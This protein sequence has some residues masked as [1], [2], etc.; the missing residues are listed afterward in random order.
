[1]EGAGAMRVFALMV[2]MGPAGWV[3][4]QSAATTY[5]TDMN[6]N[7][8]VYRERQVNDRTRVERVMD[9]NGRKVTL[10]S[11]EEKVLEKTDTRTVVEK[12][13]T[14]RAPDGAALPP[15]RVRVE[16]VRSPTGA[17]STATTV[18]RGDLNGAMK[19]AERQTVEQRPAGDRT[20]TETRI[21]RPGMSGNVELVEKRSATE[22]KQET[23][24]ERDE[25]VYRRDASGRFVESAREVTRTR[26]DNG[27]PTTET[28]EYE[29][30][31]VGPMQA[32]LQ[33]V[34][35][36]LKTPA[37]EQ[38]VVNIYG[39]DSAGRV[40]EG[41]FQLRE[42]LIYDRAK[43]DAGTVET[44]S[45]RRADISNPNKLGAAQKVSETV[46]KGKC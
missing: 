46:C 17:V 18:W 43:S 9:I 13:I 20:E 32:T 40:G 4:G 37:G 10:E 42:Q 35:Q 38:E 31:G 29:S 25:T 6:G 12:V 39:P 1:M 22:R 26:V 41:K 8:T 21:E 7:R 5:I 36:K 23:S 24:S 30:N 2:L 3:S 28:V 16:E 27:V 19:I 15:E 33:K 34:S 14:R 11:V 45:V 44:F